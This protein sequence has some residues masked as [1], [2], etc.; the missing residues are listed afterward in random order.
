[1]NNKSLIELLLLVVNLLL[2]P[3]FASSYSAVARRSGRYTRSI[4]RRS[5]S[6]CT[7]MNA[8]AASSS[9]S[10]TAEIY[11]VPGSGWQSPTWNWGYAQGTGHDC[12]A[13]CRRQYATR[14]SRQELVDNLLL[15]AKHDKADSTLE[16]TNFEE[17]KL[18]LALAWQNGRWDGSDGGPRGGYGT[19]LAAMAEANR[20]EARLGESDV[21]ECARR[22]IQDVADPKRFQLLPNVSDFALQQMTIMAQTAAAGTTQDYDFDRRRCSGFVLQAMGFVERGL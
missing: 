17:V 12:A 1:M 6:S 2:P 5:T 9:S 21:S 14:Q 3:F 16:P 8:A 11:G 13:I 4:T 7:S 10:S 22:F 18:I 20:Y 19:V 15:V